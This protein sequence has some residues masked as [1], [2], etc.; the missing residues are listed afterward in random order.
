MS[1]Q[2]TRM[3]HATPLLHAAMNYVP[4]RDIPQE[5]DDTLFWER[6]ALLSDDEVDRLWQEGCQ[7]YSNWVESDAPPVCRE[8]HHQINLHDATYRLTLTEGQDGCRAVEIEAEHGDEGEFVSISFL[9]VDFWS[10]R[11][12]PKFFGNWSTNDIL[13]WEF[14]VQGGQLS[15]HFTNTRGREWAFYEVTDF[16]WTIPSPQDRAE[17][18]R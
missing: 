13:Y 16:R 3:S 12:A 1:P 11:T 17:N 6:E 10:G 9:C 14:Q 2:P 4:G 7:R 18:A 15:L 8:F 5:T